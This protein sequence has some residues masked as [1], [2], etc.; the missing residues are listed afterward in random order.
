MKN[1]IIAIMDFLMS[2]YIFL[3]RSEVKLYCEKHRINYRVCSSFSQF[4]AILYMRPEM[5]KC[6][7]GDELMSD[8]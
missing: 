6:Q 5:I 2:N 4:G 1:F 3:K 7:E 8:R